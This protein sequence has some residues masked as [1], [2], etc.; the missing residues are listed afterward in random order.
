MHAAHKFGQGAAAL[1]SRVPLQNPF[2]RFEVDL[3]FELSV[4]G[5]SPERAGSLGST[6]V[7][8]SPSHGGDPQPVD[9]GDL[10]VWQGPAMERDA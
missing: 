3:A 1:L 8:Q 2:E 7:E 10:I 6:E 5:D 4:L 9:L